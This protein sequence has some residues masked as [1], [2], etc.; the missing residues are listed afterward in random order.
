VLENERIDTPPLE[1]RGHSEAR[2]A[3]TGDH[4]PLRAHKFKRIR[5]DEAKTLSRTT[6]TSVSPQHH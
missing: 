3:G 4:N 5:T 2:R 6:S 1:H